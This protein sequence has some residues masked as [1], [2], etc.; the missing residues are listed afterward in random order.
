MYWTIRRYRMDQLRYLNILASGIYLGL[1]LNVSVFDHYLYSDLY[2]LFIP[3]VANLRPRWFSV[4]HVVSFEMPHHGKTNQHFVNYRV[5]LTD[6]FNMKFFCFARI[7]ITR[8]IDFNMPILSAHP[9][10]KGSIKHW[11]DHIFANA[12]ERYRLRLLG[13]FSQ[14][15]CSSRVRDY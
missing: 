14:G 11:I 8:Y 12:R 3:G 4:A 6:S 13:Y 5:F 9:P 2:P 10:E 1:V 15:E 7:S